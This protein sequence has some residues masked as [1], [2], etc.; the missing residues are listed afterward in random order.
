M[1][2]ECSEEETD[3][4]TAATHHGDDGYHGSVETEGIEVCKVGC[5][6]ED[7][8]EDDAPVPMEGR[9]ALVVRPPEEQE[10]EEHHEELVDIVPGLNCQFVESHTVVL[11]R[12]HEEFIVESGYGSEDVGKD[13]EDDEAVV[14]E[15]N[16]FFLAG[17]R[18]H[19]ESDDGYGDSDPLPEVE[20]FAKDGD[21]SDAY[22][23][24]TCG[25]D[26]T[27]DGEWEVFQS[28]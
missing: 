18:E 16:A 3:D 22:P 4:Y 23:D 26:R 8:D 7:A 10:H 1:E 15:V 14:T 27:N 6:E 5:G 13:Y 9:G 11:W 2:D 25:V 24:G 28:I 20:T 19:V 21:T 12:C 17:A